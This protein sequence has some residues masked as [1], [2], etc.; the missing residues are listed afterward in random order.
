MSCC[1]ATQVPACRG[2]DIEDFV[3][4]V[5]V[6]TPPLFAHVSVFCGAHCALLYVPLLIPPPSCQC[7]F[8]FFKFYTNC[9]ELLPC[10]GC[11][12]LCSSLNSRYEGS[13]SALA[14]PDKSDGL[15]TKKKTF[16]FLAA[17]KGAP[18]MFLTI[19]QFF[20]A[21]IC[22]SCWVIIIIATAAA[23]WLL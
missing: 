19:F 17:G 10:L 12:Q 13:R 14:Q 1:L 18:I 15:K 7:F 2:C 8:F 20:S 3:F 11:V 5:T 16:F 21:L 23:L 6:E 22:F 9:K 4:C